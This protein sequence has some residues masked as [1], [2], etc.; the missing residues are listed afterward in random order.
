MNNS[1]YSAVARLCSELLLKRNK[2]ISSEILEEVLIDAFA[3][4]KGAISTLESYFEEFVDECIDELEY[5]GPDLNYWFHDQNDN[6]VSISTVRGCINDWEVDYI[7]KQMADALDS[8]EN[9]ISHA[10][11]QKA[12]NNFYSKVKKITYIHPDTHK[13]FI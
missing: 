12:C 3:L 6:W 4:E 8:I 11:Y 1:N 5:L 2:A 9:Q 7:L 13:R 10:R